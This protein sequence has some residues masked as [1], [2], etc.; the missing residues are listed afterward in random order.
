V[1]CQQSRKHS[2][3]RKKYQTDLEYRKKKLSRNRERTIREKAGKGAQ[4]FSEYQRVYRKTHPQ[5]EIRN[6]E[7]QKDRNAI[8]SQKKYITKKIVNPDALMLEQVDK[9]MVYAMYKVDY[10]KIVNPDTLM[11]QRNDKQLITKD[12]PLFV[13]LL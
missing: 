2:F 7:K 12:K 11:L 9:E 1:E 3:E 13:R 6:R 5:Y 8:R 10:Q 4:C